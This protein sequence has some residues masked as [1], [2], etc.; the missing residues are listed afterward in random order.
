M[1]EDKVEDKDKDD[2]NDKDDD[3]NKDSTDDKSISAQGLNRD[4]GFL[5]GRQ[6]YQGHRTHDDKE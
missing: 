4:L 5:R 1:E 3:N 6:G 2:N